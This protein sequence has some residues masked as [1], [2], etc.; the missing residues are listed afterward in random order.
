[1][2]DYFT[3]INKAINGLPEQ[4]SETRKAVYDRARTALLKQLRGMTPALP[5]KDITRERL[6][7]EEAIRKLEFNLIRGVSN[8]APVEKPQE[9]QPEIHLTP[10]AVPVKVENVDYHPQGRVKFEHP[11]EERTLINKRNKPLLFAGASAAILLTIGVFWLISSQSEPVKPKIVVVTDVAPPQAVERKSDQRIAQDA[12][13]ISAPIAQKPAPV[14]VAR[15]SRTILFEETQG[16]VQQGVYFE[17]VVKWKSQNGAI[18]GELSIPDKKFTATLKITQNKDKTLPASHLLEID[19]A[20]GATLK[21][22]QIPGFL[23]KAGEQTRGQPISA[24]AVKIT[25]N[26][27]LIGLSSIDADITRNVELMKEWLF[28]DFPI[29]LEGRKRAV[30]TLEK[31]QDGEKVFNEVFTGWGQ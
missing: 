11:P 8:D 24:Q 22:A 17:G 30:I 3:L 20:T 23:M 16:G 4:N 25:D 7:L 10:E 14:V 19:I 18:I 6:A 2:A 27:Y 9:P 5:E 13:V 15:A 31:G 28:L 12:P 21:I 26:S 29:E 1:M